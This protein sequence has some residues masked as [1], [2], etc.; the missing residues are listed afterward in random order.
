[1]TDE[2]PLLYPTAYSRPAPNMWRPA[3]IES[4]PPGWV[5]VRIWSYDRILNADLYI[6]DECPG[7]IHQENT[8]VETVKSWADAD[9]EITDEYG[10]LYD[11]EPVVIATEAVEPPARH[12]HFVDASWQPAYLGGGYI[13]TCIIDMVSELLAEHG[14]ADA[15]PRPDDWQHPDTEGGGEQ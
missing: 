6:I 11:P 15:I 2:T 7:L 10:E 12:R 13:G 9:G 3:G 14:F 1:M 8:I 5:N 4:L